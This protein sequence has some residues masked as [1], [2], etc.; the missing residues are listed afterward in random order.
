M[1]LQT[2]VLF[3]KRSFKTLL[4]PILDDN[5][6]IQ[7]NVVCKTVHIN[8]RLYKIKSQLDYIIL[9]IWNHLY[10]KHVKCVL[11]K[12][13]LYILKYKH[14]SSNRWNSVEFLDLSTNNTKVSIPAICP[15]KLKTLHLTFNVLNAL[16]G[17][18][19]PTSLKTLVIKLDDYGDTRIHV[20]STLLRLINQANLCDLSQLTYLSIQLNTDLPVD[21]IQCFHNLET[22]HFSGFFSEPI[23]QIRFP[24]TIKELKFSG[25]RFNQPIVDFCF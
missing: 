24:D 15:D 20:K 1:S 17:F 12:S 5:S 11:D 14:V 4:E 16:D 22:F 19:F 13:I 9:N 23:S 7:L 8:T 21:F 10:A 2:S 3:D 18:K 25:R 6:F